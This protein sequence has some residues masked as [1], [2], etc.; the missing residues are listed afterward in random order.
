MPGLWEIFVTFGRIGLLSFGGPAAQI[1]MPGGVTAAV[2]IANLALWFALH[3]LFGA[4]GE[5][6]FGPLSLPLPDWS[7][8][9]NAAVLIAGAAAFLS[10][11]LRLGMPLTLLAA[12]GLGAA[13]R[14]SGF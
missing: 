8:M 9:D 5:R 10:I 3:V 13:L 11:V 6:R 12:A 14:P 1:A 2:V 7:T 4:V